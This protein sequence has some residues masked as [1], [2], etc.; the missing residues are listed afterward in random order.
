MNS[1]VVK[2]GGIGIAVA[3]VLVIV[4]FLVADAVSGP[5]TVTMPGSD[6]VEQISIAQVVVF[7]VLGG[8]AGIGL[9]LAVRRLRRPRAAF[10][11]VCAVALLLYGIMPFSAAEA[12]S[13]AIWLNVLHVAAAVPIVGSLARQLPGEQMRD[14]E[15]LPGSIR[16]ARS[17]TGER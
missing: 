6:S 15:P 2:A 8:V 7:T 4:G 3:L 17:M 14:S 1:S 16:R 9:A 10:V 12:T 13:T 11:A 5:L